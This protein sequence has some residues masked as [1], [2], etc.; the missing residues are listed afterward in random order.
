MLWGFTT[1]LGRLITLGALPLVFWRVLIVSLTLLLWQPLWRRLVN[2]SGRDWMHCFAAGV[3]VTLHW[4]C[5]YGS[6]KLANAS[7]AATSIALA[8]VFLAI[9]Q[10]MLSRQPFVAKELLVAAMA[11]PGVMLVVGGIPAGMQAGFALGALSALLVAMF[12][13][14]NKSLAMRVSALSLT[15]VEMGTGALLLGLLIPVWPAF[16]ATFDWPG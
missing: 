15:A 16:G 9:M 12:S 14:L 8:P 11:I 1:I 2:L 7:V 6:I 5:F 13:I 3:L 10:P 4:L